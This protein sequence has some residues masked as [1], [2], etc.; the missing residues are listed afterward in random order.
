MRRTLAL[1]LSLGLL[2]A[3]CKA[4]EALDQAS[5]SRDL[6]KRGTTD[7]LKQVA[8]DEYTAPADGRLTDS[9]VQ[10]YLKVR[11]HE[12]KITE[13]AKAELKQHAEKAKVEGGK[14]IAGMMEGFKSLGSVADIATADIR[15]A[16]D[17]G[18]NSQ[19]YLWVKQQIL[20]ASGAAMVA[21][22]TEAMTAS[23]EAAYVQAKKAHAEAT[24]DI[25]KKMYGEMIAGYDKS[26]AEM[27]AQTQN[28]DPAAAHNRQLLSRY[29]NTLNAFATEMSKWSDKPV[30]TQMA[31][32]EWEKGINDAKTQA[33]TQK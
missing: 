19:E 3:G 9:Q 28:E 17:L 27:A 14:S 22:A 13:V 26:R 15:A 4:K 24:D 16:K 23:F 20:A 7:L 1:T 8:D 29:E 25:T 5:I 30:D 32:Q 31:I 10:M 2:L 33:A 6:D 21:Q 12:K 11:E 18:F